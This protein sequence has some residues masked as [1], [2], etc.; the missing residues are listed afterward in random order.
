MMPCN[1]YNMRFIKWM[2]V[3]ELEHKYE[4]E[5]GLPTLESAQLKSIKYCSLERGIPLMPVCIS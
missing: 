5:S 1:R 4:H 3:D 2:A